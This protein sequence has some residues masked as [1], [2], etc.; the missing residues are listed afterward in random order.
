MGRKFEVT[1]YGPKISI[2]K[3]I[4]RLKPHG[5][6]KV[7]YEWEDGHGQ[8]TRTTFCVG[9]PNRFVVE[10]PDNLAEIYGDPNYNYLKKVQSH[11]AIVV[12][13]ALGK[14]IFKWGKRMPIVKEL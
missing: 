6:I 13:M 3:L 10:V 1:Y 5:T 11:S 2:G 12:Q 9:H 14:N 4:E 8:T 7:V